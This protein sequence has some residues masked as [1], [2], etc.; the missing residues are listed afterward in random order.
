MSYPNTL[1][2][3]IMF[4]RKFPGIG[5]KTG[6]RFA[7]Q[8]L[9]WKA[10]E[11]DSFSKIISSLKKNIN[12]C[13]T[14]G[15]LYEETLCPWCDATKRDVTL[16]CIVSSP[17]D[18]F[19]LDYTGI[20]KGLYHVLPGLLSPSRHFNP[21]QLNIPH[22]KRRIDSLKT[23]E[24]ILAFDSTIEGDATSLF[25]KEELSYFGAHISRIAMGIPL[26][27]SIDFVDGG[28]LSKAFICRHSI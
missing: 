12:V 13:P 18:I 15:A 5:K 7:F 28:T 4:L 10:E 26:G 8:L 1:Q 21:Q 16:L 3:L 23:K 6:E 25:L 9:N 20:Y 19:T 2:K 14:C 11:L 22:L 24:I 27:C 17:K